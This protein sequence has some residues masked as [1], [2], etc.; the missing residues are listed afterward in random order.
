MNVV[1][2][3]ILILMFIE[4]LL[5]RSISLSLFN[6]NFPTNITGSIPMNT[7]VNTNTNT[8]T[9]FN[10][11]LLNATLHLCRNDPV[12]LLLTQLDVIDDCVLTLE[13]PI[14]MKAVI[15]LISTPTST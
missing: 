10:T 5:I 4:R 8:S 7:R 6:Q 13:V 9:M 2:P 14:G 12:A 3:S 11:G 1:I 15:T